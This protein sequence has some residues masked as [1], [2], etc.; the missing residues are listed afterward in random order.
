MSVHVRSH[1]TASNMQWGLLAPATVL[2]GGA[3]LLA[4]VGGAEISGELGFAWQAVAAFSAGVGMLALLL[5]LY[6]LNWR[7]ARVRAAR[8]ANPFLKPRRGGFWKGALVGT[9][10]VVAI[11]LGG[12]GVGIFYPGLIESER[13]F[14]VAVPPLALAA[15]YTVFPVAPLLGGLIGRAWRSTT[16]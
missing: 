13:N 10:V 8:A 9:L 7:A 6:V 1:S 3:G 4:F 14:F 2:L 5:L 12:I 16:L 11:Q 15:L